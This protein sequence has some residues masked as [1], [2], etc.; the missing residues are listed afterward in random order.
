LDEKF[1]IAK[2]YL[3]PKVMSECGLKK[4]QVVIMDTA[5][6]KL[7]SN[8]C[9]EAG[10]RSLQKEI[11]KICRKVA[12][13]IAKNKSNQGTLI[14]VTKETL[15]DF[16]GSPPFAN[17][18][19]YDR[20][21]PGVVIGLAWSEQ[22]GSLVWIESVVVDNFSSKFT[23][24]GSLGKTMKESTE[25]AFTFAKKFFYDLGSDRTFFEKAN[26]HMHFPE[27][28][29][30]KDGPSAGCAIA[31]CLLS[32]AIGVPIKPNLAMTGELSLTG[33]VLPIGGVKAKVMACVRNQ[34]S[35][36]I[37][38]EE[39]KKD[40]ENL[41]PSLKNGLEVHFVHNYV[42]VFNICFE[43]KHPAKEM[44]TETPTTLSRL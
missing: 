37:L 13:L 35:T 39:N 22:G 1:S 20:P 12:L 26:I 19:L 30:S 28:A 21:P 15:I 11:E 29:V 3:I 34:I 17:D 32:L 43:G 9:R 33:R 8:Y 2:K 41:P 23:T 10:V 44:T 5:L 42:D 18:K 36:L 24:T 14:T 7:I 38:P 4:E 25:I 16:C 40:F 27:G 31:T 6:T